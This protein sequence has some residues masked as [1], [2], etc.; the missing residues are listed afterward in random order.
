[1]DRVWSSQGKRWNFKLSVYDIMLSNVALGMVTPFLPV[2]AIALGSSN[3]AVGLVTA[4]PALVNT[5]MY[6][7]AASYVERQDSRLKTTIKWSTQV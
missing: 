5:I 6:L 3:A 4:I 2:Y 7:P 1:M